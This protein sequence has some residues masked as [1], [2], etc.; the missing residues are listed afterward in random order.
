MQ[1]R[2]EQESRAPS[3]GHGMCKGGGKGKSL[4]CLRIRKVTGVAE[5]DEGRIGGRGDW[6]SGQGQVMKSFM[7]PNVD[8]EFESE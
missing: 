5:N 8:F 6:S 7:G 3:T 2:E 1:K 4:A